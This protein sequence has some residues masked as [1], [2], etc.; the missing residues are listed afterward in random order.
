MV[1]GP[2]RYLGDASLK[3]VQPELKPRHGSK[4]RCFISAPFG[5][6]V[7]SVVNALHTYDVESRR[8][9]TVRLGRSLTES[10]AGEI[11]RADFVCGVFPDEYNIDSTMFEL[12]FAMGAGI[13]VIILAEA[14]IALPSDVAGLRYGRMSL[15]DS[16]TVLTAIRGLLR[17]LQRKSR[18]VRDQKF[19]PVLPA[20]ERELRPASGS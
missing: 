12:G 5:C 13:P 8:L 16:R 10:V 20:E 3:S 6:D 19:R 9:D 7:E 17:S 4:L 18:R 2:V 14:K 15:S 11:R 1:G